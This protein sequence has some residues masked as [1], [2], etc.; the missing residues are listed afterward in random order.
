[1]E[2]EDLVDFLPLF[3]SCLA[4]LEKAQE[5]NDDL[6]EAWN[7]FGLD[8]TLEWLTATVGKKTS[9]I[10][11]PGLVVMKSAISN[12]AEALTMQQPQANL[13]AM[14]ETRTVFLTMSRDV[15]V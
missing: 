9:E 11:Q 3:S 5:C 1:M 4:K 15:Q 2:V 10:E 12:D 7:F 8:C 13:Q 14:L 6:G